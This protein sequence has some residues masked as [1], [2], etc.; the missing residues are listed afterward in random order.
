MRDQEQQYLFCFQDILNL[1]DICE[2]EDNNVSKPFIESMICRLEVAY[3]FMDVVL[4][5][6][7][8]YKH[9]LNEVSNN[10]KIIFHK[11]CRKL[12]DLEVWLYPST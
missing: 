12:Q 7:H 11:W 10:L 5:H 4:P 2:Q 3:K 9:E 6:V 8:E 1:L